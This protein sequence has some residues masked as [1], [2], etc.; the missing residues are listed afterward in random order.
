MTVH[1][2]KSRKVLAVGPS[3]GPPPLLKH[4]KLMG[5]SLAECESKHFYKAL[6]NNPP[7][8]QRLKLE[9]LCEQWGPHPRPPQ[10]QATTTG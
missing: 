9:G 2:A 5:K 10:N 4:Y 8:K 3:E 7:K 6:L 1:R